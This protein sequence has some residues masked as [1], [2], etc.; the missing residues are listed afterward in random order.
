[1]LDD[2]QRE[3]E[4]VETLVDDDSSD[5]SFSEPVYF[6]PTGRAENAEIVLL[7]PDGYRLTVRV[8][9]LTGA[10]SIGALEHTPR[11][12]EETDERGK[13]PER[14]TPIEEFVEPDVAND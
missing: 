5:S 1:M 12:T 14:S 9:G 4:K 3:T 10:A 11:S 6:Y 13:A 7:G 8:R 2:E